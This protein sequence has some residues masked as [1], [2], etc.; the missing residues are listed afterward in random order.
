MAKGAETGPPSWARRVGWLVLLWTASVLALAAVAVMI[1]LFM[2][3]AGLT[4]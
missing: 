1:R 2:S 4:V 3:A